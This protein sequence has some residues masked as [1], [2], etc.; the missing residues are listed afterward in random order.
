L[1]IKVDSYDVDIIPAKRQ[2]QYGNDH[3]LYCRKA[4]TWTKTNIADHIS[5]V[6]NSN[7]TDEIRLV[8]L[9]RNQ[10][11]IDFPSFYLE[12]AT[13]KALH[14]A[15]YNH[16]ENNVSKVFFYLANSFVNDSFLDP[17]NSN[18]VISDD[19]STIEKNLVASAAKNALS[20]I[21]WSNIIK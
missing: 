16:L 15:Y 1:G 8:K 3:S 13:I 21:Y 18:N 12:L 17:A 7:R 6:K 10:K 5:L 19:L 11:G 2:S 4:N 14:Y 20:Q 9:W